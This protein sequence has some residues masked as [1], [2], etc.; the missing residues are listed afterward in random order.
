MAKI[1]FFIIVYFF[2]G[3]MLSV[4]GAFNWC[5]TNQKFDIK[6]LIDSQI[7]FWPIY[8]TFSIFRFIYLFFVF[9]YETFRNIIKSF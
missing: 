1:F 8:L 5:E 9:L 2:L 4:S 3:I 7:I 6:K